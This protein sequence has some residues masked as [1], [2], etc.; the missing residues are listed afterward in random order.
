MSYFYS[1]LSSKL[2][3]VGLCQN[4]EKYIR[5]CSGNNN[6]IIGLNNYN[7]NYPNLDN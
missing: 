5:L 3:E 4:Y 7:L 6:I 2:R 1:L